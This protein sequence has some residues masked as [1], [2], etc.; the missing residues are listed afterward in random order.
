MDLNSNS[1]FNPASNNKIFT[2]IGALTL[3]DTGYTLQTEILHENDK[4]YLIGSGDPDLSLES[5]D[6]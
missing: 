3:L 1:Q 5:L 6:S 2:A 4:L